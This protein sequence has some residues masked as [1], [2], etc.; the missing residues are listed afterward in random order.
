MRVLQLGVE[1]TP[2]ALASAGCIAVYVGHALVLQDQPH[3]AH[4]SLIV[5]VQLDGQA[6]GARRIRDR[7]VR[8]GERLGGSQESVAGKAYGV[9]HVVAILDV[10]DDLNTV[11]VGFARV[12]MRAIDRAGKREGISWKDGRHNAIAEVDALPVHNAARTPVAA[13]GVAGCVGPQFGSV[14][15]A[16][17]P[18]RVFTVDSHVNA[19]KWCR[20]SASLLLRN[21]SQLRGGKQLANS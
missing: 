13:L 6:F 5:I 9:L 10:H 3:E 21:A 20:H 12:A 7:H 11:A 15:D 18:Q 4:V 19:D 14:N 17:L 16:P 2:C 1:D 8:S